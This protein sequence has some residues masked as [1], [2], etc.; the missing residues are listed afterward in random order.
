MKKINYLIL[1]I[2][3]L[4]SCNVV[5]QETELIRLT[6]NN[7][8]SEPLQTQPQ[9]ANI[10]IVPLES[11]PECLLRNI[12]TIDICDSLIFIKDIGNLYIFKR[13]GVFI[14]QVG[15][16]GEA[17]EEY[18]DLS[19][20]YV[21]DKKQQIVI[22]DAMKNSLI[23]YDFRGNYIESVRVPLQA[24]KSTQ[25]A[26][27]I[28]EEN[29]LLNHYINFEDNMAYTSL[30]EKTPEDFTSYLP[31]NP[32]TVEKYMY[33]L[34]KHQMTRSE[35]GVDLIMPLCDTIFSYSNGNM[36]AKYLVDIPAQIAPREKFQTSVEQSYSRLVSKYGKDGFFT[37]FISIYETKNKILLEYK[38][39]G[40]L[41][42][43]YMGNKDTLEGDYYLNTID[44]EIKEFPFFQIKH[45]Y[46]NAFVGIA[47]AQHL[48][49][50]KE[51]IV[52]GENNQLI[53]LK[54]LVE[55]LK[56]DDNPV[57]FFYQ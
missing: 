5:K 42:G 3:A 34:S 53:K 20:F 12:E 13:N 29:L 50:I 19:T 1:L 9:F 32:I 31:Y 25:Q 22:I 23:K 52:T 56:Y 45:A 35:N 7:T 21:D 28:E 17:P 8:E 48:I 46:D 54:H 40:I 49:D 51:K 14:S 41:L 27:F 57:L 30:N 24:I 44:N 2:V 16:Y 47:E 6:F 39:K 55:T 36:E 10:E 11:S 43:F 4:Y 38:H 18:I 26:I 15:K 33:S 37:G